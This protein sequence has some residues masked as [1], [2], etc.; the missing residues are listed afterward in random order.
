MVSSFVHTAYS[1]TYHSEANS[2][3]ILGTGC[4]NPS[5]F[6]FTDSVCKS[7]SGRESVESS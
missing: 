1:L 3:I 2:M 6:D 5:K 4:F 7:D